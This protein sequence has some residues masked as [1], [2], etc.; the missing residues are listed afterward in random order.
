MQNPKCRLIHR[1]SLQREDGKALNGKIKL[2][3]IT[4]GSKGK[5]DRIL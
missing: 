5:E 4:V 2:S 3:K 1:D